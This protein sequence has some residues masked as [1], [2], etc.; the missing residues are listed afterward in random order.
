[1]AIDVVTRPIRKP[2]ENWAAGL[3]LDALRPESGEWHEPANAPTDKPDLWLSGPHGLRVACEITQ[4]SL[5]EWFRWQN[6]KRLR[7]GL[8]QLD[9]AAVPREVDLWLAKAIDSKKSNTPTYLSNTSAS[10]AWLLVH[11]GASGTYDLFN[12]D[13]NERYD[14]PLLVKAAE[15]TEHLFQRIYVASSSCN[16]IVCVFPFEGERHESPDI[17]DPSILKVLPVRSMAI[18]THLGV[19]EVRIGSEFKPDRERLLPLL[20]A[21]RM[22]SK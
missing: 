11:G 18:Q 10:E 12:L 13:D 7:L 19:N 2:D 1:M 21:K 20:N 9:E 17:T 5:S 4:V 15:E 22:K 16:R 6:D 8:G 3:L 14:I